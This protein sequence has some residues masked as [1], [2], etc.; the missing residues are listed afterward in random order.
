MQ[1]RLAARVSESIQRLQTQG[2]YEEMTIIGTGER[3]VR[4]VVVRSA[5]SMPVFKENAAI[6]VAGRYTPTL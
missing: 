6:C 2:R 3:Q 1:F 4:I 5:V